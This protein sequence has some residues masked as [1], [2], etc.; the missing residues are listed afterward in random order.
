[1]SVASL[2][3]SGTLVGTPGRLFALFPPGRLGAYILS[4]GLVGTVLF[5][6]AVGNLPFDQPVILIALCLMIFAIEWAPIKLTGT[7]LQ[8]HNLSA[9]A[10]V[11]FAALLIL[12][13]AGTII[14]R[15]GSATA[16]WMKQKRPFY[17]R[18][19]T[20]AALVNSSGIAALVYILLGG[21]LPFV[22][23]P[24]SFVAAAL[25]AL[26]FL[27]TNVTLISGAVSLES[28]RPFRS[29]VGSWEWLFLQLLLILVLGIVMALVYNS[30]VG[31]AGFLLI[32]ALLILPWYSIY[33]DSHKSRELLEE[34]E[35]LE[36]ANTELA[37]ANRALNLRVASLRALHDA[38]ITLNSAPSLET[39]L[40]HI[41]SSVVKLIGADT[42]AIYL[43]QMEGGKRFRIVG[44]VGLSDQY[45]QAPEMALNG[46]AI[47]AFSENRP[48]IMD[49]SNYMEAL[50]SSAAVH[51]GFR[52]I[53]CFPL[54][55]DGEVMGGL[56]VCYKT[57]HIFTEDEVSNLKPLAQ[58]ASVAI[59]NM[60]LIE[61]THEGYLSTIRAL[62]ATVEAKDPYLRGHS[63]T[64]RQ[65]SVNTGRQLLLDV[66]QIEL[67][68][69]GALFHDIGMIGVPE[70]ILGKPEHLTEGEWTIMRQHPVVGERIMSEVS[71]LAG[72][73]PIVRHHHERMDGTGYPDGI[74]AQENL[75]AA[76]VGVCD[77][78]QAMTSDRP[79][80][81]ALEH[82]QAIER[83]R[84]ASG[85]QFVPAVVD[86]FLAA[87]EYQAVKFPKVYRFEPGVAMAQ[88]T[89]Y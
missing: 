40:Q 60:Q 80:R 4:V 19:F 27:L 37:K 65:L 54:C 34:T 16:Y 44:H 72:I 2:C 13:P 83:I 21:K 43:H 30:G 12:G 1:M 62:V 39:V 79:Y 57:D 20:S 36:Q 23:D 24:Q 3:A 26:A 74:C 51:E 89:P 55:V 71:T 87:V 70:T 5:A 18:L 84:R 28:H 42:S 47:R 11:A 52:A 50:L 56:D 46:A 78:Y 77:A 9:G 73:L 66:R 81:K 33:Y 69:L 38:S 75:L 6:Y 59:H 32:G 48:L 58:Q 29:V 61:K 68:N 7:P 63:E 10:A 45:L 8:G 25:A 82:A 53:A 22:S 67:L 64:V 35:K 88:P 15:I 85:T 41:L 49:Q 17:K 76:I 31:A 14:V 86:A